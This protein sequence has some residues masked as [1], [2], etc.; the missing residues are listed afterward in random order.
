MHWPT[1]EEL[2]PEMYNVIRE[3]LVSREKILLP[4]LHIKLGLVK[5]FVKALDFEGEVFQEIRLIFPR[6]S[7]A[8]IKRETS[9]GLQISTMLKSESLEAKINEI[10]KEAWQVFRGAVNGFLEKKGTKITK[11]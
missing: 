6:Q 4:P 9:V 7:D 2:T 11:T 5:Q 8:K 10:E 3:L 1:W